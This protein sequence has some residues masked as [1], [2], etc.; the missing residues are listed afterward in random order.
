M[1]ENRRQ[2]IEQDVKRYGGEVLESDQ[3]KQAFRQTHHRW[4]TVGEHT[5]RVTMSSVLL[6]Y[7]LRKMNINV[8]IKDVVIGALCHDLGILGRHEKYDSPKESKRE[9]PKE[10]VDVAKVLV[11][12]LPENAEDII[13]R[14]MWPA[15][16]SK[17]PN[18]I[19]GAVVSVV[20]KYSAVKDLVKG[21]EINNTGV[22]NYIKEKR[23]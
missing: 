18:S 1:R 3:M 10:S 12:D 21:S 4:A 13:E 14:H 2:R 11:D 23:K 5:L 17:A 20:D 19:E 6:S 7:A 15:A 22:K 16:D 8:N 9:H